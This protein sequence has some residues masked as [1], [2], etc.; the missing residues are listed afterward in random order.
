[1]LKSKYTITNTSEQKPWCDKITLSLTTK[2]PQELTSL[3][4]DEII[5]QEPCS[6]VLP[7]PSDQMECICQPCEIPLISAQTDHSP[8]KDPSKNIAV[9]SGF[10][11]FGTIGT[12]LLLYK[13][14]PVSSWF[15]RRGMNNV[16]TDLYMNPG[17]A[18]GFLSMQG[19]NG[20]LFPDNGSNNIFY[21]SSV[22]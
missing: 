10:T 19:E 8:E 21:H 20:S 1:M 9:T 15:R 7:R 6:K 11:A 4:C 14:T 16:G 2:Y 13:F 22:G 12:L 17:D 3:N 18:E 5:S